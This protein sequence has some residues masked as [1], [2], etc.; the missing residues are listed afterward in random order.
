MKKKFSIFS[1]VLTMT[2][3][4]SMLFQSLHKYEHIANQLLEV[5]CVHEKKSAVEITHQHHK[6]HFCGICHHQLGSFT[7]LPSAT[8]EIQLLEL[9]PNN[10]DFESK[11]ITAFFKGSL[12]ALRAPPLV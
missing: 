12:F 1:F 5:H 8:F 2:V 7:F 6:F 4:V 10:I 11:E 9:Y 3:L